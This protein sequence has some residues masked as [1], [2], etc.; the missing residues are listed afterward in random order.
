M[1]PAPVALSSANLRAMASA[2][3]APIERQPRILQLIRK[4]GSPVTPIFARAWSI[5]A[6]GVAVSVTL[7]ANRPHLTFK[8]PNPLAGFDQHGAVARCSAILPKK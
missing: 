2:A 5:S 3:P 8:A 6:D 1:R 7:P 4:A